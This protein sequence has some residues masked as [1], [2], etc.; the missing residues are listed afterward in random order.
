PPS[1]SVYTAAPCTM[2]AT[3]TLHDA[4]PIWKSRRLIRHR[5]GEVMPA[6]VQTEQQFV[7]HPAT[8]LGYVHLTAAD[9]DRQ[10]A[11]YQSVLGFKLHWRKDTTAG[12][13][14]GS[15]DLLRL[16]DLPGARPVGGRTG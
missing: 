8:T 1:S 3:L 12:L 5:W 13:G 10:I 15:G 9:L 11:F 6:Q 16:T 4:L 7:I 2:S 14:G